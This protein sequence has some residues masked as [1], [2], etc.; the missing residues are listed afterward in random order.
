MSDRDNVGD[1]PPRPIFV[2]RHMY[3]RRRMA[4]AAGLLPILGALLLAVPLLWQGGA[5]A[6]TSAV[7]IFVFVVWGGLIALSALVSR[8]LQAGLREENRGAPA[9]DPGDGPA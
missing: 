7:M 4:D 3:R 2:G 6:R 5:G 1:A 9:P 8:H